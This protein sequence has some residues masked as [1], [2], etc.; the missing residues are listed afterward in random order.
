M[1][2][3]AALKAGSVMGSR[4][5]KED[6]QN[7]PQFQLGERQ[8]GIKPELGGCLHQLLRQKLPL[9]DCLSVVAAVANAS[10]LPHSISTRALCDMRS[11]YSRSRWIRRRCHSANSCGDI[12]RRK[13]VSCAGSS[14][15][16][17]SSCSAGRRK[18]VTSS[19]V[20]LGYLPRNWMAV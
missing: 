16:S 6:G 13:L 9:P 19:M 10:M 4:R 14:N 7:Q 11:R 20:R 17:S 2:K 15:D 18:G 5:L 12:R 8:N 3:T 1:P